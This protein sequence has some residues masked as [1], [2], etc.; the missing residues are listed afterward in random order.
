MT[1][2]GPLEGH[3]VVVTRAP[4]QAQPL[5]SAFEDA[6]AR[7]D[8]LPLLEVCPGDVE[9]TASAAR[10]AGD[11]D[12]LA[13]TSANAVDMFFRHGVD[14]STLPPIGVV[15]PA[16]ARALRQ[17]SIIPAI[18]AQRRDAVG[19]A[20]AL[21]TRFG[22]NAKVLVPQADDARPHLAEGLE[23]A[24]CEVETVV[25]YRKALP[26]DAPEALE[27]I[28]DA[29]PLDWVTFTSPRI[30]RHFVDLLG[31]RWPT[32]RSTLKSVS[33]G[34][35]TKGALRE[36]GMEPTAVA[37]APGVHGLVAAVVEWVEARA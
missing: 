20:Q 25:A 33:I 3:R 31:H 24:G 32:C 26:D 7:V 21:T 22:A 5:R 35:T 14:R 4:H 28:L 16:T 10:R 17:Q 8:L 27:R 36:V 9:Q 1:R 23:A 13:F 37:Q 2:C 18:Q 15:G 6:G 11:F 29:G 34:E 19:L 12:A 30:V